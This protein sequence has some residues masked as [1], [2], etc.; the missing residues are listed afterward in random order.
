MDGYFLKPCPCCG[1]TPCKIRA[2]RGHGDRWAYYVECRH[3]A[4]P[5][6][7]RTADYANKWGARDEW[8]NVIGERKDERNGMG[9]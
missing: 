7:P 6:N 9:L 4:C 2:F 1:V 5:T 3:A 8:N